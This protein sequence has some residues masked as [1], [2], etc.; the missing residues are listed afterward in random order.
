MPGGGCPFE[1]ALPLCLE[2]AHRL[3]EFG[4]LWN[5]RVFLRPKICGLY[6]GFTFHPD[7]IPIPPRCCTVF[8]TV[9]PLQ[10]ALESALEAVSMWQSPL[11]ALYHHLLPLL[12]CLYLFSVTYSIIQIKAHQN[13]AVVE[14]TW[15]VWGRE[16]I[17]DRFGVKIALTVNR[18]VY[19]NIICL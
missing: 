9:C 7:S 15:A 2:N 12:H 10:S 11:W 6:G 1:C 5:L 3:S 19:G 8:Y 13:R 18:S 17:S 16:D 14:S 4:N